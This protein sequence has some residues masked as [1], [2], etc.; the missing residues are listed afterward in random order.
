M[1]ERHYVGH[2][3]L[4]IGIELQAKTDEFPALCGL[5]SPN[6]LTNEL[7]I[8]QRKITTGDLLGREPDPQLPCSK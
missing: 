5:E 3:S 6:R 2:F 4:A 7:P 1:Y 8:R